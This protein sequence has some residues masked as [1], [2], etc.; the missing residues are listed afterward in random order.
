MTSKSRLLTGHLFP[1]VVGTDADM[2]RVDGTEGC[3][4]QTVRERF[5]THNTRS[6]H[7]GALVGDYGGGGVAIVASIAQVAIA[8]GSQGVG[9]AQAGVQK[10]GVGLSITLLA[11][12]AGHGVVVGVDARGALHSME[13][14]AVGV[15]VG[16]VGVTAVVT[17]IA[18]VASVAQ[19]AV[20]VATVVVGGVRFGLSFTVH[21]GHE[22]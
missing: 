22:G 20:A 7:H 10:S 5:T 13:S 15:R 18:V 19:M 4:S 2:R 1:L 6:G 21:R 16:A 11:C 8:I 3:E 17:G 9:I 12:G 14:I